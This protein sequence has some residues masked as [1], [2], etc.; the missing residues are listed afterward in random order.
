MIIIHEGEYMPKAEFPSQRDIFI[1]P[2]K[3]YNT[4]KPSYPEIQSERGKILVLKHNA[5]GYTKGVISFGI[6]YDIR[7]RIALVSEAIDKEA[8]Y[9]LL[10]YYCFFGLPLMW[11]AEM[12][13]AKMF[14]NRLTAEGRIK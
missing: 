11:Q 14:F 8:Y 4:E 5:F 10:L 3:G 9:P 12:V 1:Y 13:T 2:L 7:K 6:P